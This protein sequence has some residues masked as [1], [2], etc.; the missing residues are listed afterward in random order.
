MPHPALV[1]GAVAVV[2]GGAAGIGLAAARQFVRM[3]LRVCVADLGAD[4]LERAANDLALLA[5]GG[6][7]DVFATET[8]VS[9]PH[10]LQA[11][12]QAVRDRFGGTDVLMNNAG[13]QL[14]STVLGP[15]ERWERVLP[16]NLWGVVHGTQIFVPGMLARG[17][18]TSC[19]NGW[20]LGTSTSCVRTTRW[21]VRSTN[22]GSCGRRATSS[23]TD[24]RSPVGTRTTPVRSRS[25]PATDGHTVMTTFPRL[26]P[27]ST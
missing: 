9:R 21:R 27:L 10:D 7:A 12:E 22:A 20:R 4:R 8:D 19:W 1:P 15:V 11:L 3:G 18:S 17:P 2:T 6:T 25:S 26:C 16:V 24:R 23:R 14:G 5:A 13:V